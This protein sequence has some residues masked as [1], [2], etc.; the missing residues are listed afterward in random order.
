MI[1]DHNRL[2]KSLLSTITKHEVKNTD[3]A[4]A[5]LPLYMHHLQTTTSSSPS[6]A[7]DNEKDITDAIINTTTE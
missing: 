4:A 1:E 5:I 2:I 7:F 3:A 6:M